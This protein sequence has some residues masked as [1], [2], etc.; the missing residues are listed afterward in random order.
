[1]SVSLGASLVIAIWAANDKFDGES[2]RRNEGLKLNEIRNDDAKWLKIRALT[3]G[4]RGRKRGGKK[5]S[6]AKITRENHYIAVVYP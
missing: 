1:L 4:E 6:V 3:V 2:K 5:A